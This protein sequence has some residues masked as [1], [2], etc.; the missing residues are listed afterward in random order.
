MSCG[1]AP[2]D[3]K[4]FEEELKMTSIMLSEARVSLLSPLTEPERTGA[5]SREE[6]SPPADR[7]REAPWNRILDDLLR[8]RSLED[9]WDGQGASPP[10]AANVDSAL[11]W[12]RE[13]SRYPQALPPSQVVPGVNGEVLL[14]WQGESLY[15]EAEISRPE[16]VEWLLATPGQPTRQWKTDRSLAWLVVPSL[17]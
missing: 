16:E 7:Q 8:L 3:E 6:E 2:R 11:A 14:V 1:N 15:L 17:A 10:D 4:G 13:M 12:V 9:D 5:A